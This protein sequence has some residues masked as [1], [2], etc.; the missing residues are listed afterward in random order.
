MYEALV[1]APLQD[2]IKINM[3]TLVSKIIIIY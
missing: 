3:K 1:Y 2:F